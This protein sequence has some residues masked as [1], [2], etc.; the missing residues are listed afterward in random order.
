M[1]IPLHQYRRH[2]KFLSFS[3][4]LLCSVSICPISKHLRTSQPNVNIISNFLRLGLSQI[5]LPIDLPRQ[6]AN[7]APAANTV[8][9]QACGNNPKTPMP[10]TLLGNE[11][12]DH[13]LRQTNQAIGN[14]LCNRFQDC[15]K[16]SNTCGVRYRCLAED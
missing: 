15:G 2:R 10:A 4:R 11:S 13:R 7:S 3:R 16:A 5:R 8:R 12:Y 6:N 1:R 9:N 14:L